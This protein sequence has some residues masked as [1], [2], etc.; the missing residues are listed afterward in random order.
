MI[1]APGFQKPMPYFAET[2]REEVVDLAVL[3]ERVA[4][5][6]S[7]APSLRLD[8]V[9]AVD[10][11]RHRDARDPGLHELEE[12]H[13]GRRVLHRDA[14]GPQLEVALPGARGPAV[15]GSSRW[16]RSTFSARVSG[17]PRRALA[18]STFFAILAYAALTNSGVLSMAAISSPPSE[19]R[20]ATPTPAFDSTLAARSADHGIIAAPP[21][22]AP[23]AAFKGRTGRARR[24]P[25][26]VASK[27]GTG[28]TI[29]KRGSARKGGRLSRVA[30]RR[31]RRGGGN[32]AGGRARGTR[33]GSAS[34]RP[35][36]GARTR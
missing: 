28:F 3:V 36:R 29:P 2:L 8:Q 10:R 18:A 19:N 23:R 9:V 5:C 16:P 32:R 34:R 17:R 13:L 11:R 15:A 22:S 35:R 27:S 7:P 24:G 4:P 14:V 21:R 1:P 25:L 20:L 30:A 31:R 26:R 6:P 12:R 33:R